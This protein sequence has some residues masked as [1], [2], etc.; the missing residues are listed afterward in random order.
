MK[1]H[2]V[3]KRLLQK[4]SELIMSLNL[5]LIQ[6]RHQLQ[7]QGVVDGTEGTQ[8]LEIFGGAEG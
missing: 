2:K 5:L 6:Q 3:K 4:K 8:T 1:P 7:G